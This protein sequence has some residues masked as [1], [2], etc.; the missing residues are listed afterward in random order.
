M[1][2]LH[3]APKTKDKKTPE[4]RFNTLDED[5]P[6]REL[7]EADPFLEMCFNLVGPCLD[8]SMS[9]SPVTWRELQS[10]IGISGYRLDGWESQQI[11]L[12]SRAYVNMSHK[13][14]EMGCPAPYNLA[15]FD[16]DAKEI[17]RSKVNDAFMAMW[18][19]AEEG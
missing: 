1:A 14:S 9:L 10:F 8:G 17:N 19:L 12:M 7:P 16:E 15:A 11:I 2:W 3:A 18:N 13:A 5:D 6:A 4:S